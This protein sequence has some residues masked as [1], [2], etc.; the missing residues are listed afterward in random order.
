ME[1]KS[2][3]RIIHVPAT[4]D[5]TVRKKDRSVTFRLTSLYEVSN[6]EFAVMDTF[7]QSAGHFLFRENA[8]V[9]E[10]I[11]KEDVETDIAKSQSTQIRDA[12]WILYRARGGDAADKGAWDM[13]YRKQNQAFKARILNEVHRIQEGI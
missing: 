7:H 8:F 9:E 12:L 11:P 10:D 13:F 4:L 5:A 2:G 3:N 6:E 1:I